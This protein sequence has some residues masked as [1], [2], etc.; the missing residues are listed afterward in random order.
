MP[1][2]KAATTYSVLRN[3]QSLSFSRRKRKYQK[4]HVKYNP[5]FKWQAVDP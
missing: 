4:A 2:D 3:G 5:E 1:I